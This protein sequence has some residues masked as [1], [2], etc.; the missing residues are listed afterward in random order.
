MGLKSFW[1]GATNNNQLLIKPTH[2]ELFPQLNANLEPYF[3]RG[4]REVR[5]VAEVGRTMMCD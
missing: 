2:P 1:Q 4:M 5:E 3:V